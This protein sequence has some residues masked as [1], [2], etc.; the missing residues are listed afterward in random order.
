MNQTLQDWTRTFRLTKTT[1]ESESYATKDDILAQ[2]RSMKNARAF[3]TPLKEMV[4]EIFNS[5]PP[6]AYLSF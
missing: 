6:Q 3:K 2:K 5:K 1:L 4:N